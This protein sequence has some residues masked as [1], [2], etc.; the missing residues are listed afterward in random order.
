VRLIGDYDATID[1][2]VTAFHQDTEGYFV[3]LQSTP[4]TPFDQNI[5]DGLYARLAVLKS[6]AASLPKYTIISKQVDNLKAQVDIFYK[7]DKAAK[8]PITG[9][10]VTP[11]E[12]A[13]SVSVESILKLELALK[14]A[15]A[16]EHSPK[17]ITWHSISNSSRRTCWR[18][19][20][21]C[22][23]R[24]VKMRRL[25]PRSNSRRSRKPSWLSAR[26]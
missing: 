8:R 13:I 12:S 14:R 2:G 25:S 18:P 4:E 24:R 7:L 21:R 1:Q 10:I 5:Y 11:A 3:K 9:S 20:C 16:G 26:I 23:A 6:R 17:E 22:S 15:V 19:R